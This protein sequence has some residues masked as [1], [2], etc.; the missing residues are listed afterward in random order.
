[1]KFL[2]IFLTG[3]DKSVK[4]FIIMCY[5][6]EIGLRILRLLDNILLLV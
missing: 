2:L 3:Y 6:S 4:I 5:F 1:M